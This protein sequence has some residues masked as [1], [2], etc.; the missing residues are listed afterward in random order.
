[1]LKRHQT[2]CVF[3][4]DCICVFELECTRKSGDVLRDI[5]PIVYLSLIVFVYFYSSVLETEWRCVKETSD[6]LCICL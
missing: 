3:F 1:M 4:L 6:Q 2:N 5:R